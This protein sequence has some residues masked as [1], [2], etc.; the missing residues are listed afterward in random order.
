M[1]LDNM[2]TRLDKFNTWSNG[3]VV[4][5]RYAHD[6]AVGAI[7]HA[8][9]SSVSAASTTGGVNLVKQI[10]VNTRNGVVTA[11][12]T[13]RIGSAQIARALRIGLSGPAG[14]ALLAAPVIIDLMS[15]AGVRVE[16]GEFQ[17]NGIAPGACTS[18]PCH[19]YRGANHPSLS[20]V[21]SPVAACQALVALNGPSYTYDSVV[22]NGGEGTNVTCLYH[23]GGG[24]SGTTLLHRLGTPVSPDWQPMTLEEFEDAIAQMQPSPEVLRDIVQIGDV[25]PEVAPGDQT[26]LSNPQPS[27]SKTTTTTQP[28]GSTDTT[29]CETIGVLQGMDIRLEEHCTTTS[30]DN[31][32]TVTGV[33]TTTTDQA[34]PEPGQQEGEQSLFCELF[35]NVL[36]CAEL[37]DPTGDD[38]PRS[39]R[40]VSFEPEVLFGSGSCPADVTITS[41]GM[42]VTVGQWSS[43][44]PYITT[45]MRPMVLLLAAFAAL[46]IVLKGVEG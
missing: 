10:G 22:D 5:T 23:F 45:Y 15:D 7:K 14:L 35:P 18:A 40:S 2:P 12:A 32:G 16:D 34:D 38:I 9:R 26:S 20:W 33:T 31:T 19:E 46:M 36:A 4:S 41:Q 3:N 1:A 27:P 28:D 44:C 8:Q 30:R 42:T 25:L 11:T 43:W 24:V 37:G 29:V 17:S 39:E 6:A 21:S 13:Q